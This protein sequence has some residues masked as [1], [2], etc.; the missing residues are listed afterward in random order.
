MELRQLQYFI[1]AARHLNFTKAAQ[2]CCI[3]QSAMSQQISALETELGVRLFDRTNRGLRL[4]PEGEVMAHEA[5]R[6]LDQAEITMGIV[7]QARNRYVSVLRIGIHANLLRETLPRALAVFRQEYP[8]TRVLLVSNLQQVLLSELREGQID[9]MLA[10]GLHSP[11]ID[12]AEAQTI[13]DE[14]HYAMLPC[15]HPLA[16]KACVPMGEL[17]EEP[18]IMLSGDD[19]R[20][21]IRVLMEQG[22]TTRVYAY[23]ESQNSVETLVAAGYGVSLCVP[24]AIRR[25]PGIVYRPIA[26]RPAG[27]TRLLWRKDSANADKIRTLSSLLVMESAELNV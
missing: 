17:V 19:K 8:D 11:V 25:H 12:W 5:R 24:S 10:V 21:L 20:E 15:G 7:R 9:C 3:V 6:L 23:M 14:P 27:K 18:L 2:E 26:D 13:V 1:A 22:I 16:A 4:T